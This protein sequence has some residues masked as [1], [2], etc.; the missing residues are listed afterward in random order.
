MKSGFHKK[1][2]SSRDL[3]SCNSLLSPKIDPFRT[4]RLNKKKPLIL[5]PICHKRQS[6]DTITSSI[7]QVP[8]EHPETCKNM[9]SSRMFCHY[10]QSSD[11][12]KSPFVRT[13]VKLPEFCQNR[14]ESKPFNNSQM[15][16]NPCFFIPKLHQKLHELK[17]PS[18]SKVSKVEVPLKTTR[19]HQTSLSHLNKQMMGKMNRL[20]KRRS[21][22]I[23]DSSLDFSFGAK[24]NSALNN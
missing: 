23:M 2:F 17:T 3:L 13:S 24:N 1:S 11:T 8:I 21:E 15:N 22:K 14:M 9:I 6:S 20:I 7:I 19:A 12:I 16:K 18:I 5:R 10:R 4:P